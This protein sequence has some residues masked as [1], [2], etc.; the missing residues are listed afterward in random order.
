MRRG[1]ILVALICLAILVSGAGIYRVAFRDHEAAEAPVLPRAPEPPPE[2]EAPLADA[3]DAFDVIDVS[4]VVEVRRGGAWVA[5]ARGDRVLPAEAL[6]TSE[7]GRAIV[8]AP[9]GDELTL[10]ERVE[11]E[12]GALSETVTEATLTRGRVRAQTAAGTERLRISSRGTDTV[13]PAGTRFT[14]YTDQRGAVAVASEAGDVKV[15]AR[16][17]VVTVGERMQTYVPPGGA[18]REPR[19]VPA[20]VF[21]AVAWPSKQVKAP[22]TTV[23][24]KTTPGAEVLVNGVPVPVDAEG[25]FHT[26]VGLREGK[27]QIRVS[28]EGV[29]GKTRDAETQVTR[30]RGQ[31]PEYGHFPDE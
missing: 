13:A 15:I 3:F 27:N 12:V 19:A 7:T 10:R 16:G 5:I 20:D 2:A 1:T 18:P 9:S 25:R 17:K 23:Q 14:V 21:L 6:R 31:P 29:D 11:L 8:R 28:A 22:R 26:E 30:A 24:G 4:G